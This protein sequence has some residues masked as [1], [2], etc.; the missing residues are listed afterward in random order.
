MKIRENGN[1]PTI[2]QKNKTKVNLPVANTKMKKDQNKKYPF[3]LKMLE[4]K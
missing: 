4:K 3:F 1:G 2:V